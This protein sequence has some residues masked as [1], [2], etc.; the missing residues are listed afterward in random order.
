MKQF[1]LVLLCICY[2]LSIRAQQPATNFTVTDIDGA[3]HTLF[4]ILDEGKPVL[5][6]FSATWCGPCWEVHLSHVLDDLYLAFGPDGLDKMELFY[7]ESDP[8]TNLDDLMGLTQFS[9]GDWVTGT[10]YPI[11]DLPDNSI[12]NAYGIQ[13]FPTLIWVRKDGDDYVYEEAVFIT[14]LDL[15]VEELYD[16]GVAPD[17]GTHLVALRNSAPLYA[18]N[19]AAGTITVYNHGTETIT[20]PD[21]QFSLDGAVVSTVPTGASIAP[22]DYTALSFSGLELPVS[23]AQFT[24]EVLVADA[25]PADNVQEFTIQSGSFDTTFV[26]TVYADD[27]AEEE[28]TFRVLDGVGNEVFVQTS[29]P[30]F[31]DFEI[32]FTLAPNDCYQFRFED[33]Y[34]DGLGSIG[35]IQIVDGVGTEIYNGGWENELLEFGI[36]TAT[37]TSTEDRIALDAAA[38]VFPSPVQDRLTLQFDNPEAQSVGLEVRDVLGRLIVQNA[39]VS[40]PTGRQTLTVDTAPL[41]A[42]TYQLIARHARGVQSWTF[43]K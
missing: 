1:T 12:P 22:G 26:V 13:G 37:V 36:Q 3:E 39:S 14:E 43:V 20:N 2:S 28:T 41:A 4:D 6:D 17:D 34:G 40:L 18:C 27:W 30:E 11:V 8:D 9:L 29:F 5:L 21:V 38:R 33:S 7:M 31:E 42:G 35:N 32:N 10:P 19:D 15:A 16:N 24:A 25:N 23:P